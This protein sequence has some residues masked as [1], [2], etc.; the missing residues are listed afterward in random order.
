MYP[1]LWET[2]LGLCCGILALRFYG[3]RLAVLGFKRPR[4]SSRQNQ[5][6]TIRRKRKPS[7]PPTTCFL[8]HNTP[9]TTHM[10]ECHMCGGVTRAA[11]NHA[12]ADAVLLV[13]R[14]KLRKCLG[15]CFA[16]PMDV[17]DARNELQVFD[18][19]SLPSAKRHKRD[20]V[21]MSRF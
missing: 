19:G 2:V 14:R 16:I 13:F 8:A 4:I 6:E 10:R 17:S 1:I 11:M 7:P 3:I 18:S 21:L 9:Y 20:I 15:Y 12:I 5:N